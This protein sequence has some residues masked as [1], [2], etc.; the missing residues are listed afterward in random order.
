MSRLDWCGQV[1]SPKSKQYGLFKIDTIGDA[2][3]AAAWLQDSDEEEANEDEKI[4]RR[5]RNAEV[6]SCVVNI[7][8]EMVSAVKSYAAKHDTPIQCRIGVSSGQVLA[9]MLGKLQVPAL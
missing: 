5:K 1:Y 7:A 9:G 4:A 6:C 3:E 2:Y 8:W